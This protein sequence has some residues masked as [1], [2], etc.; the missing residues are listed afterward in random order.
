MKLQTAIEFFITYGWAFI[1]ISI[2]L[3]FLFASGYFNPS[4]YSGQECIITSGFNC[5]SFYM[6]ANGILFVNLQQSLNNP[7]NITALGCNE[8]GSL[9]IMQKPYNP[10]YP[11]SNQIF[12]PIGSNYTFGIACYA[13]TSRFSG[14]PGTVF[15]GVLLVN[16]TD[17]V[18]K[19]PG[20]AVGRVIVKIE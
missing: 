2:V 11:S 10:N 17:E 5:L 9:A 6:P 18:T 7:I 4:N 14:N 19:L 1:L 15:S 12:M 8:N 16:Y 20:A 13:G 3:F